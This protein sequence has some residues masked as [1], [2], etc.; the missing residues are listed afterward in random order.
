MKW[1]N[2]SLNQQII[3][4]L[5]KQT[6]ILSTIKKNSERSKKSV[7]YIAE[8]LEEWDFPE[9]KALTIVQAI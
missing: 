7:D 5:K 6:E 8:K 2:D 1:F 9:R 3:R 4:E